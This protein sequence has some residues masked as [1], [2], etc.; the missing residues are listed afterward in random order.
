MS[1]VCPVCLRL[2]KVGDNLDELSQCMEDVADLEGEQKLVLQRREQELSGF[3]ESNFF[4]YRKAI[5]L[6]M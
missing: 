3:C 4:K 2:Y 6:E 1:R 5:L